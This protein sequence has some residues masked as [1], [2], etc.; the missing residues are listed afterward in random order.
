MVHKA[1]VV[2]ENAHSGFKIINKLRN[3]GYKV[4]SFK[5]SNFILSRAGNPDI[6]VLDIPTSH[7]KW[8]SLIEEM[9]NIKTTIIAVTNKK[10]DNFFERFPQIKF[11]VNHIN[12]IDGLLNQNINIKFE[13]P[14]CS[15]NDIDDKIES[16]KDLIVFTFDGLG[17]NSILNNEKMFKD[18]Y[19][20]LK[21]KDGFF[22]VPNF[23]F[24][25]IPSNQG[26]FLGIEALRKKV[27]EFILRSLKDSENIEY[28]NSNIHKKGESLHAFSDILPK[29]SRKSISVN[30]KV[31]DV[32]EFKVDKN[33]LDECDSNTLF[34]A[35]KLL[36]RKSVAN[37]WLSGKYKR[38]I[39]PFIDVGTARI[40]AKLKGRIN[41]DGLKKAEEELFDKISIIVSNKSKISKESFYDSI[42]DGDQL[43][44]L[45][46]V[47]RNIVMLINEDA[48]FS[49]IVKEIEKDPAITSKIL[50]F[51]NSVFYGLRKEVRSINKAAVI[52]G[53]E[54]LLGM[55]LS[56]S[57]LSSSASIY[58]KRLYKYT[59]ATLAIAKYIESLA[60]IAT[61]VTLG[62]VVHVIGD[63]F[64]AQHFPDMFMSVVKGVR[65]GLSY[66]IAQFN[67]LPD[68]SEK[69]GEFLATRWNFPKRA[70]NVIK[71]Y[72]YPKQAGIDTT[73]HLVHAA[74]ILAK[75]FGYF[76]GSYSKDDL[77]YHTYSLF[78]KKFNM[79]LL[80]F[81]E[82]HDDIKEKIN[83]MMFIL[84]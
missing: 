54:E 43:M 32:K 23:G 34:L 46:E 15:M 11:V 9:S 4:M 36:D 75:N 13:F 68:P 42:N 55:S 70:I 74:S 47:Q 76:F 8:D 21:R 48:P 81:F 60:S 2:F 38:Y 79:N 7:K 71:Y 51:A 27:D 33:T 3:K 65:N 83:E 22:V 69:L 20:N 29:E 39:N 84:S 67:T 14:I 41:K 5:P 50:K 77:N 59:I 49:K 57:Y 53:T 31:N 44:S 73:V 10:N 45:P 28:L 35:T 18:I 78:L 80:N 19:D 52:L 61:G 6:V 1:T 24:V 12:D 64:Y 82:K 62:S 56:I 37:L 72:L 30:L 58:T 25:I 66:K 16:G 40:I 17:N 63:M 26:D